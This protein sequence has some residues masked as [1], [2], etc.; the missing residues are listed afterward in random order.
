MVRNALR[1]RD[2]RKKNLNSD[3]S[4][5]E[6][7]GIRTMRVLHQAGDKK[8]FMF[9]ITNLFGIGI[10]YIVTNIIQVVLLDSAYPL[11]YYLVPTEV[12]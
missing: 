2:F 6:K 8:I 1:S 9:T 5:Y 12:F 10:T 11:S 4:R 7:Q 3:L